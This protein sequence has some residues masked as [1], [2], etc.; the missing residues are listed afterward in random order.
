MIN[1]TSLE[2]LPTQ[3]PAMISTQ[4]GP[5]TYRNNIP[6]PDLLIALQTHQIS[7]VRSDIA[8]M[9]L[10]AGFKAAE[11]GKWTDLTLPC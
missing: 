9:P 3:I 6:L 2:I 4:Q 10:P 7:Y 5:G 1:S 8:L 11:D